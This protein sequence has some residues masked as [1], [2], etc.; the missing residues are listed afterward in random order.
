MICFQGVI[1]SVGCVIGCRD[2]VKHGHDGCGD[3][4]RESRL[5]CNE[6]WSHGA[7]KG[8]GLYPLWRSRVTL[9]QRNRITC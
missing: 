6:N 2:D 3:A 4:A 7:Q 1:E 8:M 9:R 5:F